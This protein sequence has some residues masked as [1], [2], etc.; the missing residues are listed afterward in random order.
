MILAACSSFPNY[1]SPTPLPTS[2]QPGIKSDDNFL[3]NSDITPGSV[4]PSVTKSNINETIC[5]S[6]YTAT[7]RPSTSYTNSIKEIQ[8]QQYG[9]DDKNLSDYEEDHLIPLSSGG[10]PADSRNLWPEP[11]AGEYGARVKDKLENY[12]HKEV[13]SDRMSLGYAQS[14]IS[15]DWIVCG[16]SLGVFT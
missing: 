14:C 12:L 11:Y 13:C 7:V 2:Y 1:G 16:R 9:Y 15:G 4:D 3:P 6:G 10:S 8:I 5:V